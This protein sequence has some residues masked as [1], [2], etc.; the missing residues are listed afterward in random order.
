MHAVLYIVRMRSLYKAQAKPRFA[1]LSKP[2]EL[3]SGFAP[4]DKRPQT[5]VAVD[6]SGGSSGSADR[7]TPLDAGHATPP[8]Y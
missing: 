7:H 8:V 2:L 5:D 6:F 4:L 1:T 3:S